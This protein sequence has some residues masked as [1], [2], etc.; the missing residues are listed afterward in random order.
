MFLHSSNAIAVPEEITCNDYNFVQ[1]FSCQ[2]YPKC[3]ENILK[4]ENTYNNEN[5]PTAYATKY[6]EKECLL[7]SVYGKK[8]VDQQQACQQILLATTYY[9]ADNASEIS[10]FRKK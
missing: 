8:W 4:C 3:L 9:I 2:W 6:G 5:E 7:F 1:N 10:F